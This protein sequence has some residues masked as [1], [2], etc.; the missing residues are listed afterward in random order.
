MACGWRNDGRLR[1]Q[2]KKECRAKQAVETSDDKK[3]DSHPMLETRDK[4]NCVQTAF[5]IF[6]N[7]TNNNNNNNNNTRFVQE[8]SGLEL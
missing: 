6:T 7:S 4:S 8:V 5:K 2:Q 1:Q 3:H